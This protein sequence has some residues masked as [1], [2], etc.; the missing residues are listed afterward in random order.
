MESLNLVS[1]DYITV[2]TTFFPVAMV[3]D[4]HKSLHTLFN[5]VGD[6]MDAAMS[7]W[8]FT[9]AGTFNSGVPY[10]ISHSQM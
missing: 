10:C 8:G 9:T 5:I 1:L 4:V 7:V 6:A 3:R 2:A